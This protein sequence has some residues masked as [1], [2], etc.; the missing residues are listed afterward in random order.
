M[1][2]GACVHWKISLGDPCSGCMAGTSLLEVVLKQSLRKVLRPFHWSRDVPTF[3]RFQHAGKPL[4]QPR[5][6]YDGNSSDGASCSSEEARDR[7]IPRYRWP[8]TKQGGWPR[9]YTPSKM[10]SSSD[11]WSSLPVA[12]N[13]ASVQVAHEAL[14]PDVRSK[15]NDL[16]AL[17]ALN[18]SL[19]SD[20]GSRRSRGYP[21]SFSHTSVSFRRPDRVAFFDDRV[22][23]GGKKKL[24]LEKPG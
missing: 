15:G 11:R 16:E 23:D 8:T 2:A 14:I 21:G 13:E 24:M 19:S 5:E 22:E 20:K 10:T 3:K 1:L 12:F 9:P 6:D 17:Q 18:E 7:S 4:K